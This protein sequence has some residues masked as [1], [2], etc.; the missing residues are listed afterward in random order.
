M[1]NPKLTKL[2]PPRE[3]LRACLDYDPATGVLTWKQRPREHFA[4]TNAWAIWNSRFAGNL[5]GCHDDKGY[6]VVTLTHRYKAHRVIW[7]WMTGEEPP[8]T[9]DHKGRDPGNN[10]WSNL[11]PATTTEQNW[12]QGDASSQRGVSRLPSGR[13]RAEISIDGT[14][15]HLG[16]FDT[17]E[18]AAA[19]WKTAARELHG[20]F[21]RG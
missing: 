19:A 7:K 16:T 20:E 15:R 4:T 11:R 14:N 12:N 21:F 13:Y 3:Y 2:L 6:L 1:P 9:L 5:A 18:E 17:P 8:E 10:R